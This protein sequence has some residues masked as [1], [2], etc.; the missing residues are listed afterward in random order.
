MDKDE[1]YLCDTVLFNPTGIPIPPLLRVAYLQT[2][3]DST[4]HSTKAPETFR[5]F[6]KLTFVSMNP[7]TLCRSLG[8]GSDGRLLERNIKE[9]INRFQKGSKYYSIIDIAKEYVVINITQ[10]KQH[11]SSF[12]GKNYIYIEFNQ[13]FNKVVMNF[14]DGE[15]TEMSLGGSGILNVEMQI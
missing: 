15:K 5:D 12:S 4:N 2:R 13:D 6:L 10:D 8:V 14:P 1:T 7:E 11:S 3:V 9:H